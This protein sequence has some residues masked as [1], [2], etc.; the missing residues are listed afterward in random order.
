MMPIV[1]ALIGVFVFCAALSAMRLREARRICSAEVIAA[2][3]SVAGKDVTMQ[4]LAVHLKS[5][6][7]VETGAE[8]MTNISS[9][10]SG[11]ATSEN[12]KAEAAADKTLDKAPAP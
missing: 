11:G 6:E 7:G 8:L 1:V 12:G 9:V 2:E 10:A 3:W 5:K 4:V